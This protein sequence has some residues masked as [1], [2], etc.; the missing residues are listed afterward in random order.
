MS[1]TEPVLNGEREARAYIRGLEELLSI[2]GSDAG[3][4][5]SLRALTAHCE[6]SLAELAALLGPGEGGLS[7]EHKQA[8]QPIL[9]EALRRNAEVMERAKREASRVEEQLDKVRRSVR[10][11][12]SRNAKPT[13]GQ[14]CDI[15]G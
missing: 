3:D 2:F 8:L 4:E 12:Q 7:E 5:Q 11:A 9:R 14:S 15:A 6:T 1:P 13:P 10:S